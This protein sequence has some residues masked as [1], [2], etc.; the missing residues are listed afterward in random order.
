MQMIFVLRNKR[1]FPIDCNDKQI[2]ERTSF[3]RFDKFTHLSGLRSEFLRTNL[4]EEKVFLKLRRPSGKSFLI[5]FLQRSGHLYGKQPLSI[6]YDPCKD[7]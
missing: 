6:F 5:T 7:I 4:K 1:R 2:T 3:F